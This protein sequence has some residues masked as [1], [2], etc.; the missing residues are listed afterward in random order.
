MVQTDLA[1]A[2]KK[3]IEAV[4]DAAQRRHRDE[5]DR[6][7]YKNADG[8][9]FDFHSLRGQFI[10]AM[11]NAGVSLKTLQALAR[12]SRVETTLKHYARVQL[13]DV[14]SALDS[15]P[16]LPEGRAPETLRA[17]G[18]D[19]VIGKN[20]G[21]GRLAFCLAQQGR[22]QAAQVDSSGPETENRTRRDLAESPGESAVFAANHGGF[23]EE[24]P[25]GFEPGMADLQSTAHLA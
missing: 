16:S 2:K 1:A 25:P 18:T 6:F 7:A 19:P 10:S 4:T 3:W 15:L 5:S 14:R 20:P 8:Q 13:A 24:A 12:H 11:E 9:F 17:T 23:E 22:F 21:A